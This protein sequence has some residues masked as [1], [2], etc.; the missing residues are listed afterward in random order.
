MVDVDSCAGPEGVDGDIWPPANFDCWPY[1]RLGGGGLAI[2]S[3][4]LMVI[5]QMWPH[6]KSCLLWNVFGGPFFFSLW[7]GF[8]AHFIP[9]IWWTCD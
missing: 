4:I 7:I 8:Y 5:P 9:C 3:L 1:T 6:Y 2:V